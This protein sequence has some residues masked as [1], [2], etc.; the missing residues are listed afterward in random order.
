MM[1]HALAM[2]SF[3]LFSVGVV[4]VLLRRSPLAVFMSIE[5]MLN[6][7]NILLVMALG[8]AGIAAALPGLVG[9]FLVIA[10]AAAEV[11]VGLAIM[12]A[13]YRYAREVD[14]DQATSLRG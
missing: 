5:L 8:R 4:G 6:A 13:V 14:L 1:E 7:A 9:A 12:V 3:W 11:A 2:L 10:V